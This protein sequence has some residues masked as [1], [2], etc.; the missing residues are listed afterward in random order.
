[1]VGLVSV[2]SVVASGL[3]LTITS[4]VPSASVNWFVVVFDVVAIVFYGATY[5]LIPRPNTVQNTVTSSTAGTLPAL[6]G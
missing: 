1:M 4:V 3:L 2:R 6:I 5:T